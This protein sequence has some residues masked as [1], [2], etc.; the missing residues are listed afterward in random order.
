MESGE[1]IK[2]REAVGGDM[3]V[4]KYPDI[5]LP[6]CRKAIKSETTESQFTV[7]WHGLHLGKA[8]ST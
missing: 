6:W 2:E 4:I 7:A 3:L 8:Q 5:Y 1:R